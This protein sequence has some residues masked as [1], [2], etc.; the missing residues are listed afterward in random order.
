MSPPTPSIKRPRTGPH[1][2][3]PTNRKET[4]RS[5]GG[6]RTSATHAPDCPDPHKTISLPVQIA[7]PRRI[8]PGGAC[9]LNG[10]TFTPVRRSRHLLQPIARAVCARSLRRVNAGSERTRPDGATGR[11]PTA[12]KPQPRAIAAPKPA[13][14]DFGRERQLRDYRRQHGLCFRCG[15]KYSREHQCKRSAQSRLATTAR[16]CQTTLS[17]H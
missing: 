5:F 8:H 17:V 3:I 13:P 14:D 4:W 6:A 16:C 7:T 10:V 12:L 1:V 15:E 9:W 11:I 2:R